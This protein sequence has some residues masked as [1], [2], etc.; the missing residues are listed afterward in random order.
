MSAVAEEKVQKQSDA[1]EDSCASCGIAGVDDIKLKGCTGCHLVKYCGVKCQRDH[2]P[3][4]KKECKKRA[5]ELRDEILF[6]QP[7]SRCEGD[8]PIC[9][10][11]LPMDFE[12]VTAMACCCKIICNGCDVANKIH[13]IRDGNLKENCAFCRQTPP[14]TDEEIEAS[15]LKRMEVNDPVAFCQMG[16]LRYEEGNYSDAFDYSSKAAELGDIV[17]HYNLSIMCRKAQG[18]EK[19]MKKSIFHLEEA[20]IGGELNARANLGCTEWKSGRYE[21]AVKHYLIAAKMGDDGSLKNLKEIYGTGYVSK[22]DFAAALR[23]HQAAV[24]ATKSPQR[25]EAEKYLEFASKEAA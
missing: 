9:C 25:E 14:L 5:A 6:K 13:E 22:E 20:A 12:K 1:T 11:P 4:H 24:D 2:R 16:K 15:Y 23:E 10:L 21:R 17:S 18:V 19:D 8:C 3:Q 7:E